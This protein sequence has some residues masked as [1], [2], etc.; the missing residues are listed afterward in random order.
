[1]A[2]A[3]VAFLGGCA[4]DEDDAYRIG[5][6]TDCVGIYRTLEDAELSGAQLPL[7]ARGAELVGSR[8]GDGITTVRF[9]DRSI[10]IV[11]GCTETGEF[12]TMFEQVRR[13]V[14]RERV[15]A[16]VGGALGIDALGLRQV[17]H[18]YP[19][20]TFVALPDGARE[21]TLRRRPLNLYRFAGDHGQVVAGLGTY[22]YRDLGWRSA[23]VVSLNWDAGWGSTAA[24]VAEFCALG[25]TV[26][27][28]N[29]LDFIDPSGGD[30]D[31]IPTGVDGVAVLTT[32][33]F[34]TQR[35]LVRR[36]VGRFGSD[37]IVLGPSV[38]GERAAAGAANGAI[39]AS[40]YPPD[41]EPEMAAYL[42]SYRSAFPGLPRELAGNEFVIAT[43]NAVEALLRALEEADGSLRELETELLGSPVR[44]D[45][46]GQ[47]I[48]STTLV[49][50]GRKSTLQPI[51][52]IR[53]VDQSIGGLLDQGYRPG[54]FDEPCRRATPPPWAR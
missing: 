33:F 48:I 26:T 32:P 50:V 21:A 17:A 45:E 3:F 22:A 7:I 11:R 29:R 36:L 2:L 25:G 6:L 10:E 8:P 1:M 37:R 20:V 44:I 42:S 28:Q 14:E 19:D 41:D 49:R 5:L 40:R 15:H 27:T 31:R 18:L 35:G 43:R 30:A 52:T 9:A 39:G 13:L 47:A 53:D 46:N 16:V 4:G 51:R 34:G 12:T 38:L 54:A 24:F 23:A